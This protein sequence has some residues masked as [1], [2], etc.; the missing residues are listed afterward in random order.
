MNLLFLLIAVASSVQGFSVS[1]SRTSQLQ[2]QRLST[3]LFSEFASDDKDMIG[4]TE[5]ML[6][7]NKRAK[8][9]GL[10]QKYGVT[11]KKDGLD[12]V[13]AAVWGV[14]H[15]SNAI[16]PVLGAALVAGLMLN[17]MGYGYSFE[18]GSVVIDSLQH[19]RQEEFFQME[20]ARLTASAV[21]AVSETL[22][23]M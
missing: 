18:N 11:I 10:Q 7:E 17:M 2:Q 20:A 14:F 19:I 23:T 22:Q 8:D 6:L 4:E 9:L 3:H 13:R 15:A 16:F 12:G 1:P 5:R 21:E